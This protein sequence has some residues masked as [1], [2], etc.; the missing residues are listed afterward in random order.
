MTDHKYWEAAQPDA[1]ANANTG[2]M[3][4]LRMPNPRRAIQGSIT[5]MKKFTFIAII[6]I[7]ICACS[8]GVSA[9]NRPF[10]QWNGEVTHVTDGDTLW[11]RPAGGGDAV[12]IRL[13][14][15]DAPEICQAYG[16][17]SRAAL[18]NRVLHQTVR[19]QSRSRDKYGR[20]IA[21]VSHGSGGSG[22]DVGD[23]MVSQG[24]AWANHYKRYPSAYGAQEAQAR[25][26]K[27]GLFAEPGAKEPSVF[28]KAHGSCH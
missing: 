10:S 2:C 25:A 16:T 27:R 11:V 5:A 18:A 9:K 22:D 26:A 4:F 1:S 8:T 19:V 13:D 3:A 14:G 20:V 24:H 12:K 21:R 15:I 28:R 7:A 6:I 23:F 17:L